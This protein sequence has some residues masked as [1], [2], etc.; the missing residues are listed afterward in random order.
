MLFLFLVVQVPVQAKALLP[1]VLYEL[2]LLHIS[3]LWLTLAAT[4]FVKL[5]TCVASFPLAG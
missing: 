3:L 4:C 5:F 1:T 2:Y